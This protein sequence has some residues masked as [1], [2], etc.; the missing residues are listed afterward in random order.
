MYMIYYNLYCV[1]VIAAIG[2][3]S[4]LYNGIYLMYTYMNNFCILIVLFIKIV[5]SFICT[6]D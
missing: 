1:C 2:I 5:F 4:C 3:G 6:I